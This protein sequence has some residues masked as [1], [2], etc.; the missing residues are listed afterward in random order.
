MDPHGHGGESGGGMGRV[1]SDSYGW[2]GA[3]R[4]RVRSG[5]GRWHK[6]RRPRGTR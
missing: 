2:G 1:M 6:L 3:G 4:M 5:E